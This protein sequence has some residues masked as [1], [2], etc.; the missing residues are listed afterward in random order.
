MKTLLVVFLFVPGLLNAQPVGKE[1]MQQCAS[2]ISQLRS[3]SYQ[4]HVES[5]NEKSTATVIN[6][7]VQKLPIFET[8]QL[9]VTGITMTDTGSRQVSYASDGTAFEY[10]NPKLN[11][12]LRIDSPTM[13]KLWRTPLLTDLMIPVFAYF[14]A[15]PFSNYLSNLVTAQ[16]QDDTSIY[17]VSCYKIRIRFSNNSA[18]TGKQ[19][20]ENVLYIGKNDSLFY[21]SSS[22][23]QRRF[24]RIREL[25]KIYPQG[26]FSLAANATVKTVS[27]NEPLAEGLLPV[28]VAAPL[29]SLPKDDKSRISLAGLK[30][31]VVL[32]DFWGTWC[33]PC[34]KAM[35]EIQQI[36][37]Y[38]KGKEVEVIGISVETEKGT[39]PAGFMKK[40]GFSYPV[41]LDGH[42]IVRD[43]KVV[44]FPSVYLIDRNGKIIHRESGTGR[45]NFKQDMIDRI[46]GALG[47]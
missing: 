14:E 19:E 38:F 29:W 10:F 5:P 34:I 28:G 15:E 18:L 13:T 1:I 32:L 23:S 33:V 12:S 39:D 21:G 24:I 36:H 42:S 11:E 17:N 6:Q 27:G 26:T 35:P 8:A 30:G 2:K 43:Y 16:L 47:R 44:M 25:N 4:V 20:F 3:I 37:N 45:E 7:R 22:G 31:K 9:K 46:I 41:A 40:K